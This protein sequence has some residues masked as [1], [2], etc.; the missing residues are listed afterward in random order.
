M[1]PTVTPVIA[2]DAFGLGTF[3]AS[4]RPFVGMLRNGL[5]Y[6]TSPFLGV[7]A[8]IRI[9]LDDWDA[10]IDALVELAPSLTGGLSLDAVEVL[11]PVQPVG[12]ILCAGANYRVHVEQIV[13][14]TL[15]N[16]GDPRTDK[17]LRAFAL[18]TV[19]RQ[20]QSDP[21][22]F[23]GLPSA[24]S[25]AQDDVILWTPG[26][27][28]DWELELGV[29]LK[30]AAHRISPS[31]AF[32]HIAGFV[33]S[34]DITVRD[35]MARPNVPLT[36]FVTS[37]NRPTYFPTGPVILPARFVPDYRRLTITLKVNGETMQDELVD[38]IIHGVEKCVSYASH[39]TRLSAGDMILTGS[40]AGNAG[41]H[42]NRWLRPGD[43]IEA[44]ISGLGTQVTR[45]VAPPR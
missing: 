40:P 11:P 33:M 8:T 9:L 18:D 41:K 29:I 43:L 36:D 16:A 25:G 24:V 44:S 12:Q 10:A 21:F 13:Y 1:S 14:S 31:E 2:P 23:V 45:C 26:E 27:Q 32:D 42:G 35:V 7:D 17:E 5:V 34:N 3:V 15:R 28:H 20:A 22:M 38:D 6:D 4:G 19:E 39:S 30:S 37:K